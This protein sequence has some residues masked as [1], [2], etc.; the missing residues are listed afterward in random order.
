LT[1]LLLVAGL[2]A[3]SDTPEKVIH[4]TARRF[5]YAPA[6]ITLAV[7]V[8]VILELETLDRA[9]G[10][11]LTEF[12]VR[13]DIKPGGVT[14]VRIVP[15]RTGTFPF[16]CDVFCGKGHEDMAGEIRVVEK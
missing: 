16:R 7:G 5:E 2:L 12:K 13:E 15:S 1:A 11:E 6:E 4:I 8:P 3:P 14:R 9:H 10:F